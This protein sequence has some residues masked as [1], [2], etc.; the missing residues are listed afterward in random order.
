MMG[1]CR[2]EADHCRQEK[3][4]LQ[5][6]LATLTAERDQARA[7]VAMLVGALREVKAKWEWFWGWVDAYVTNSQHC[8]AAEAV[9][10]VLDE[11]LTNFPAAAAVYAEEHKL[12]KELCE[13]YLSELEGLRQGRD[14]RQSL[15]EATSRTLAALNAYREYKKAANG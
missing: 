5:V 13:A 14:F 8:D 11:A 10:D 4:D 6:K 3:R 9:D 12:M 2:H 7:E 1:F 15:Q